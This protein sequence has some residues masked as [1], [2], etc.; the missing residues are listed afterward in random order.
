MPPAKGKKASGSLGRAIIRSRFQGQK[1]IALD[2]GKLHTTDADDEPG[3]VKM[4]SITQENDLDAFLSTAELAGTEFTAERLNVKV[5][6]DTYQ[7]PFL[8]AEEEEKQRL[9]KQDANVERLS[10]PRKPKWDK[11]MTAEQVQRNERESFLEWRRSMAQLEEDEGLLLTPFEKNIEVWRQLW[12]VIERSQLVV[13]IVDARNP[14]LFRS[15]D[16]EKYVK[17]VHPEKQNLLLINK[18][19]FLT[20]QQRKQWADHF[21]SQGI[22]YTFF[23]AVLATESQEKEKAE[24][25]REEY[26][27]ML[28]EQKKKKKTESEDEDSEDE[29]TDDEETEEEETEE[30]E[31]EEKVEKKEE[32]KEED[33]KDITKNLENS[34]LENEDDRVRIRTTTDLLDLLIQETPKIL[35]EDGKVD[36]TVTIGLVGYPNVGKSSTINAIIGEKRVSVSSTPGKTKHFQTIHLTPSLVLCDCP[37]LV[38]PT[39][40]TTKADQVCNGVLPIDQLRDHT[41]PTGLVAKRIPQATIEAIYGIRIRTQPIEDG[42]SGIPTYAELCATYAIAR[43]YFRSSQGTPDESRAARYILKD[44]VNGKLLYCHPPPGID[45]TKFNEENNKAALKT[46]KKL[47][48]TTRVPANALNYV[49]PA[50]TTAKPRGSKTE[51]VDN[52][53]FK[54]HMNAPSVKGKAAASMHAGFSRVNMYPHQLQLAEDGSPLPQAQGRK[55]RLAAVQ[56]N[57]AEAGL[58]GKKHKKGKKH[59]KVRSGAGYDYL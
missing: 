3:W 47:A 45:S 26:E 25:E 22:R 53:F 7:N 17:E 18:A 8:L 51:A 13:Q 42:G 39:F 35:G 2:E 19:D 49:A 31:E 33:I 5:V 57:L 6:Q 29:E 37:G 38:F 36:P 34:K 32:K 15:A 11:T 59:V 44:Y 54:R 30:E 20:K 56:A 55:A 1:A 43:G 28:E 52:A 50:E 58:A 40:S 4:Q 24:K 10:V 12:R 14:L 9:E 46:Q 27:R 41:G 23:S 48:P 21:D 16:L